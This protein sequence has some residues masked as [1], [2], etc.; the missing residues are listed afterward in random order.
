MHCAWSLHPLCNHTSPSPSQHS[1]VPPQATRQQSVA[2]CLRRHLP[3]AYKHISTVEKVS[4][5]SLVCSCM[6]QSVASC[7]GQSVAS[8]MGQSVA[9]CMGQSVAS[10]MGQSVASCMGQSVASCMGQSVAS[11]MGQS[12]ASCRST[13]HCIL[14]KTHP[15]H[16]TC[17]YTRN[18]S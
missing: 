10:C 9:S 17:P 11:C 12:V 6:G 13:Q 18:F 1:S 2:L 3:Q 8:C 7:M 5:M 15:L 4:C 14:P 16:V